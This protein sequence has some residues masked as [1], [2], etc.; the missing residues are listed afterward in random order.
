LTALLELLRRPRYEVFPLAGIDEQADEHVPREVKV[1]VTSSPA[2]GIDTTLDCA[3]KLAAR[4][5]EVVPHLAARL[6]VDD[7]HL[8]RILERLHEIGANEVL[9][10]AGDIGEP[11]GKFEG[12]YELLT[13]MAELGHGLEAIGI[14]G[15]PESHPFISDE[16][17]IEAMFDQ[18]P[19]ATHIVSQICF[20]PAVIAWWIGAVRDRGVSLP[21]FVGIPGPI[22]RARL[23]RI[24]TKIGVGESA[25]FLRTHGNAFARLFLRGSYSPG[26]LIDGLRPQLEEPRSNVGSF[27]I[28]TFNELARTERWRVKTIDRVDRTAAR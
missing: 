25:R 14:S 22:S 26:H 13:A 9:V 6:V 4:G 8:K 7:E 10:I 16:E 1:T 5:F 3:A 19:F 11:R 21:I 23:L 17:T 20:E 18:G 12:A 2:R 15:Y 24:S 27:H 28:Y